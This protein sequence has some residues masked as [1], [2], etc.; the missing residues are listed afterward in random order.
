MR[1]RYRRAVIT[2]LATVCGLIILMVVVGGITRLTGSGLSI[3]DW[4]PIM[5]AIPPLD[6]ADWQEAF[7]KYQAIPQFRLENASMTLG[8]FK[9]I[10]FW[11]YSHRLL[12]RLI[13]VVFFLPWLY[14]CARRAFT[15]AL[16][17]RLGFGFVLGGLQG[18]L[19]WFMVKSGL[20][21]RVS[22]S[23]YRLAAHLALALLVLGYLFWV[24]LDLLP[25]GRAIAGA[26]ARLV[27]DSRRLRLPLRLITGLLCL[28]II[29]G[30]FVAGLK[31]GFGYNTFPTMN[32]HWFPEG[33]FQF[34][35]AWINFFEGRAGVQFTHR[36]LAWCLVASITGVWIYAQRLHLGPQSRAAVNAL[37][38][39][40]GVQFLLGALT[41][42][43]VV[44]L[45]LAG[46]HQLGACGL[47]LVAIWGN[48]SV[49]RA[50]DRR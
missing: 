21:D 32:G 43:L 12:G 18:A 24:L 4:K 38:A 49:A 2:W 27:D 45:A 34:E 30:A 36:M 31:A 37:L 26:P 40:V 28:Q 6:L 8:Q 15:P 16:A 3:T 44:P 23:H 22:V 48:H 50:S 20:V 1:E 41:V 25:V 11:E 10:F 13:G 47:L 39:A 9:F 7:R 5:G 29:Y 46:A 33:F 19:G 42:V 17:G 35:P 14:F